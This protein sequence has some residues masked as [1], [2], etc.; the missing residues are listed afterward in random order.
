LKFFYDKEPS[1]EKRKELI[2][3]MWTGSQ[4]LP[5]REKA[6]EMKKQNI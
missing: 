3:Q 6:L 1:T 5:I 4:K 2:Q